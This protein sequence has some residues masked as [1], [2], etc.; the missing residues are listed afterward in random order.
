[1]LNVMEPFKV[2]STIDVDD[3]LEGIAQRALL[4]C[5]QQGTLTEGELLA[6]HINITEVQ[7]FMLY[8]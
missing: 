6:I 5:F 1:M 2:G 4:Q 7:H 3:R 8:F